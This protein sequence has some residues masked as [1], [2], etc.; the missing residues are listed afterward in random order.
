MFK[1][2][3]ASSLVAATL[4]F[5]GCGSA[6]SE[7]EDRLAAQHAIDS[8]DSAAAIAILEAKPA[9]SLTNEDKMTLA[10]AY[11]QEAEV[12]IMDIVSKLDTEEG[13]TSSFASIADDIIGDGNSSVT[14]QKVKNIDKAI[15][16]YESMTSSASAAPSF[17]ANALDANITVDGAK[18]YL[19]MAYFSKVTMLLSFFGDVATL[20]DGN[21]D[22]SL[23]ATAKAIKC[24]YE[25]NDRATA[26]SGISFASSI[27]ITMGD[28][29]V[30]NLPVLVFD[31]NGITYERLASAGTDASTAGSLLI[32]DYKN[33]DADNFN[34]ISDI[35]VNESDLPFGVD[36]KLDEQLL[37]ALNGA[38]EL[39]IDRAPD[40]VKK[41]LI[42]NIQDIDTNYNDPNPNDD[43]YPAV[44]VTMDE[45]R[46]YMANE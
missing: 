7:G 13:E 6:D 18:L 3:I 5:S 28:S 14:T 32:L 4:I 15:S 42:E 33:L 36:Y 22:G 37:D 8:G 24:I 11:M 20:E 27:P 30:S 17:K 40:D 12:S 2:I 45:I 35:F 34:N 29:T 39:I 16:Y 46:A 19:G 10:S 23:E 44:D 1:K 43:V 25:T 31:Y 9:S 41:D 38:F 26:C 21:P